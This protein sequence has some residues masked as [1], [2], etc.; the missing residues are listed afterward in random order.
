MPE[1]LAHL[2]TCRIFGNLLSQRHQSLQDMQDGDMMEQDATIW[3]TSGINAYHE[4][5]KHGDLQLHLLNNSR[6]VSSTMV[7][8]PDVHYSQRRF[9]PDGGIMGDCEPNVTICDTVTPSNALALAPRDDGSFDITHFT[10]GYLTLYDDIQ[11]H[12]PSG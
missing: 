2:G 6:L 3:T 4:A 8:N 11:D 12:K 5:C 7:Q 10:V 9:P 1:Y